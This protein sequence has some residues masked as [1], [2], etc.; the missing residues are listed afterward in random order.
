PDENYVELSN[1]VKDFI[2]RNTDFDPEDI[3]VRVDQFGTNICGFYVLP[4]YA[5]D[6][7]YD[8]SLDIDVLSSDQYELGVLCPV[9]GLVL[10]MAE[11][12]QPRIL[13]WIYESIRSGFD[14]TGEHAFRKSYFIL[15][16][17]YKELY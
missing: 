4:I 9:E 12:T 14:I 5:L 1:E 6:A 10:N 16:Q 13:S 11:M 17:N 7:S 15:N 2:G 8:S 3:W